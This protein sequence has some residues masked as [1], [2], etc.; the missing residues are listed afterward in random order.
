MNPSEHPYIE[1][2]VPEDN[3]NA[4]IKV[5]FLGVH[6]QTID[7]SDYRPG[8]HV[9]TEKAQAVQRAEKAIKHMWNLVGEKTPET[10]ERAW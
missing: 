3:P 6:V 7:N 8:G 5:Y 9:Y 10:R 1:F 4:D 2:R